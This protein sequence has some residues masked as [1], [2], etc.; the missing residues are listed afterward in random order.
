MSKFKA[1]DREV[2]FGFKGSLNASVVEEGL[3]WI[4]FEI[5]FAKRRRYCFW[6][7]SEDKITRLWSCKLE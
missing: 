1:G 7:T 2:D 3:F 6:S 4:G 5:R